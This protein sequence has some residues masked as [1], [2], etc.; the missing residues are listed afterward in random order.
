MLTCITKKLNSEMLH[1]L[2]GDTCL[3]YNVTLLQ[4]FLRT[5]LLGMRAA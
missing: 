2:I 3:V 1:L 4:V 5:I